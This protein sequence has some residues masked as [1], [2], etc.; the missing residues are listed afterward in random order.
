MRSL[1]KSGGDPKDSRKL[2]VRSAAGLPLPSRHQLPHF[3][4][5]PKE[6]LQRSF[7]PGEQLWLAPPFPL[8]CFSLASLSLASPHQQ[9]QLGFFLG[10][11][12]PKQEG[13]F[14]TVAIL[15]AIVYFIVENTPKRR[16]S[17]GRTSR[18]FGRFAFCGAAQHVGGATRQEV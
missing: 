7:R 13:K 16:V 2:R 5:L 8:A 9:A 1:E 18:Y 3:F 10:G 14:I 4:S 6:P 15:F 17:Y 11:N 12:T